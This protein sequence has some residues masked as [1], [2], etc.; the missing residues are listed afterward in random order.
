MIIVNTQDYWFVYIKYTP[1]PPTPK[2]NNNLNGIHTTHNVEL[3]VI[4]CAFNIQASYETRLVSNDVPVHEFTLIQSCVVRLRVLCVPHLVPP[5]DL[6]KLYSVYND[7]LI[8]LLGEW[9]VGFPLSCAR[10][11]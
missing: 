6:I 9:L 8:N 5:Q 7:A 3:D 1:P 2:T 4:H 10:H 11:S